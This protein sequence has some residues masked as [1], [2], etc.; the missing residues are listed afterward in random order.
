M[1]VKD[2]ELRGWKDICEFMQCDKRTAR[3]RL[4]R[5]GLLAYD[6][7][8]PVLNL[9]AYKLSSVVSHVIPDIT[10]T[11]KVSSAKKTTSEKR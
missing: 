10:K 4:R 9:E 2:I 7:T 3:T 1:T 11:G 8:K 5:R 6:G